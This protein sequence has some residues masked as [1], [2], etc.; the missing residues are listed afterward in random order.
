CFFQAEDGIRDFHVTGVQTCALPIFQR[1][2]SLTE[3]D[4]RQLEEDRRENAKTRAKA[5]MMFKGLSDTQSAREEARTTHATELKAVK[6]EIGR[7]SCRERMERGEDV[8]P[9]GKGQT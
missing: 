1:E 5:E 4:K 7:A 6:K 8:G 9:A 2:V 3:I